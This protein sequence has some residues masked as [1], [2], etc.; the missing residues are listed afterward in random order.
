[1]IHLA[2]VRG[3]ESFRGC[4]RGKPRRKGGRQ[5]ELFMDRVVIVVGFIF[6]FG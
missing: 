2:W 3:P 5:M 6:L 4:L 1:M